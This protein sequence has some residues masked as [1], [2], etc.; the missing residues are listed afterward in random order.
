VDTLT[1]VDP[2]TVRSLIERLADRVWQDLGG[3]AVHALLL[4][5]SF[6]RICVFLLAQRICPTGRLCCGYPL[7]CAGFASSYGFVWGVM[8][9]LVML[10]GAKACPVRNGSAPLAL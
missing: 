8:I 6:E 5:L 7:A 3:P 9:C 10:V 1:S 4:G 2:S